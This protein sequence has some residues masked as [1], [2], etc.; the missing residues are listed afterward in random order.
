MRTHKYQERL[1]NIKELPCSCLV[2]LLQSLL[3]NINHSGDQTLEGFLNR[4]VS[5]MFFKLM[6]T[7]DLG[8]II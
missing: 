3:D 8:F 4:Q 1:E 7:Y 5:R 2:A 6:S